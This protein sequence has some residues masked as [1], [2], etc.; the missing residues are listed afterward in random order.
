LLFNAP[1]ITACSLRKGD[2]QSIG[3]GWV[4]DVATLVESD[5]YYTNTIILEK[6]LDKASL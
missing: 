3:F 5:L 1:L 2:I 4:D 6:I